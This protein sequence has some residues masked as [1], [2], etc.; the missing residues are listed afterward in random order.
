MCTGACARRIV[1]FGARCEL[2]ERRAPFAR[3]ASNWYGTVLKRGK[4]VA[5]RAKR[6]LRYR[7]VAS[8]GSFRSRGWPLRG[9]A[10]RRAAP[11]GCRRGGCL[12]SRSIGT[13]PHKATSLPRHAGR[14]IQGRLEAR[15]TEAHSRLAVGGFGMKHRKLVSR[16]WNRL[17]I[18][19]F[20]HKELCKESSERVR[21]RLHAQVSTAAHHHHRDD[22]KKQDSIRHSSS[23]GSLLR[24]RDLQRSPRSSNY[25]P[26]RR[27]R[28]RCHLGH[29]CF[30]F[31]RCQSRSR[32]QLLWSMRSMRMAR[33]IERSAWLEPMILRILTCWR[34]INNWSRHTTSQ[35]A[36]TQNTLWSTGWQRSGT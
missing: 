23:Q 7:H 2:R 15:R 30:R 26:R 28:H 11:S 6:V 18:A 24:I 36:S 13:R 10:G 12:T 35:R 27:F 32:C 5:M 31:N 1:H 16:P 25:R 3:M 20:S 9:R 21:P 17:R 8:L 34:S 29:L 14:T 4:M 19:G 22:P 33:R